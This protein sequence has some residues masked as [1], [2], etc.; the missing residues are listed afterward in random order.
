MTAS[1]PE[2]LFWN[3]SKFSFL[4]PYIFC[5]LTS[6]S[7]R[8]LFGPEDNT[9]KHYLHVNC[10][11]N[12]SL[13]KKD[14]NF[15]LENIRKWLYKKSWGNS[16]V[17][18]FW[19]ASWTH[20]PPPQRDADPRLQMPPA[21]LACFQGFLLLLWSLFFLRILKMVNFHPCTAH[22]IKNFKFPTYLTH[23]SHRYTIHLESKFTHSDL[24][25]THN[26]DHVNFL[27]NT[28]IA[29]QENAYYD[30]WLVSLLKC[31]HF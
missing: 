27:K 13:G 16:E 12:F 6:W 15:S 22:I 1:V 5:L 26:F 17:W 8:H 10:Y 3:R 19:S 29:A 4:T 2:S 31:W 9:F 14:H 28:I 18:I 30:C 23:H 25:C 24:P 11:H 21:A 7:W 20:P